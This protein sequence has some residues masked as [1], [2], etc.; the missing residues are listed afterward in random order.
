RRSASF[1]GH[2]SPEAP[3]NARP[4]DRTA[5]DPRSRSQHHAPVTGTLRK[6]ASSKAGRRGGIV[7]RRHSRAGGGDYGT[8]SEVIRAFAKALNRKV[9]KEAAK[10]AKID[11]KE[12]AKI[13]RLFSPRSL[14]CL[15]ALCG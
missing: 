12:P 3:P 11:H 5:G 13:S 4:L 8:L 7:G 10:D 14:R 9:R 6:R 15:C 2:L 1:R